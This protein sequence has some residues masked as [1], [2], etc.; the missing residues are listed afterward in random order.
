M[1]TNNQRA[2][3]TSIND[4]NKNFEV[5]ITNCQTAHY[6]GDNGH[7]FLTLPKERFSDYFEVGDEVEFKKLSESNF[8]IINLTCEVL[9]LS[10]FK[11]DLIS[12][13]RR[14]DNEVHPL[15]RCVLLNE[16]GYVLLSAKKNPEKVRLITKKQL[17]K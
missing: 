15:K 4:L 13:L 3:I 7:V 9:R 17:I 6:A 8:K 2:T 1:K 5:K 16:K 12:I 14:L 10:R 11:R